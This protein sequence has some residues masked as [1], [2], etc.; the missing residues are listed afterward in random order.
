MPRFLSPEWIHA[1][2][3]ALRQQEGSLGNA[4]FA[5]QQIVTGGPDGDIEYHI[6]FENGGGSMKEGRTDNPAVT[7]TVEHAAAVAIGSGNASA[8]TE[9]MAGRLHLDGDASTLLAY[10]QAASALEDVFSSLRSVTEF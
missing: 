4:S 6:V 8:Q 9:F 5:I 3:A 2:D 1:A 10:G 7:F